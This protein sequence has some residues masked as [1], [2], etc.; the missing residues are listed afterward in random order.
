MNIKSAIVLMALVGSTKFVFVEAATN[1]P[2]PNT[3]QIT[4]YRAGDDGDLKTGVAWP[5]PRFTDLFDG[6][7]K[8]NL[9]GLEWVKAPHLLSG[10]SESTNWNS[11]IDFCN[12]LV[13]ASH[14]DWRLPN[15]KELESLVDCGS[16]NLAL[17][18]GHPFVGVNGSYYWS[19]TSPWTGTPSST[20]AFYMSMDNSSVALNGK[21]GTCYVWP[22]RGGQ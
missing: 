11:A 15:V 18:V 3:G 20:Y 22:V 5:Y 1:A 7:V 4:S 19:G 6:T 2:V 8:D 12:N 21:N 16:Y 9:T 13:Y 10:N 17:P 14:S